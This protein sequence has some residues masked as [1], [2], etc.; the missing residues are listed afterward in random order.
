MSHE[1]DTPTV[2]A[3]T[4]TNDTAPTETSDG[5]AATDAS[6][7]GS[8]TDSAAPAPGR[9]PTKDPA[10]LDIDENVRKNF[11][12]DDHPDVTESIREHGVKSPIK[13]IRMP[14]GRLV[15]RDGQVRTLTA[16]AFGQTEVP[17]WITDFDPAVDAA[18]AEI[19]RILEQITVNDR[20][21]PLTDG[22]RAA[23]IA[24]ALDLGASVTRVG[25][26]LQTKRDDVKRAGKIGASA[27]AR[28]LVD[29]GQYDLEQAAVI[30]EYDTLGDTDAVERL[31]RAN[32]SWF[33]YEAN[34][35]AEDRAEVRA[36]LAAALPYAEAGVG[37]LTDYPHDEQFTDDGPLVL[38]ADLVDADG[39][40]VDIDHINANP[41][42]WSV[43]L[44]ISEDLVWVEVDT[45]ALVDPDTVDWDT[46]DHPDAEPAEGLRHAREV[47]Q[48]E[49]L[50]A[51]YFLPRDLLEA[52]GLR[53]RKQDPDTGADGTDPSDA[54]Q[55]DRDGQ[56][57]H[58]DGDE[59]AAA[60]RTAAAQDAARAEA[61]AREQ[62]RM[63][64]RRVRELNKQG[65]AAKTTRTEFVTRLL[66]RKTSPAQAPVFLAQAL[67]SDSGL[68]SECHAFGTAVELL[69]IKGFRGRDELLAALE[70]AKPARAQVIVLA[71]VLGAYESRCE[72][73][74][75]RYADR[76]V[77]RYLAF[78]RELGHPLVPVELAALGEVKSDDIDIDTPSAATE[79]DEPQQAEAA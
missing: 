71:L 61:E 27:T 3:D 45:G 8:D 69:G 33:S 5:A 75:W 46:R 38:A 41:G 15:V 31:M 12:L 30:G 40:A 68:L 10:L 34:R 72:K 25:K 16:L 44:E 63:V 7:V 74:L 22:D 21:I 14:D 36:Y 6:D 62:E 32:R 48:R 19:D 58:G 20:R 50:L 51:E 54:D 55:G 24:L 53:E 79:P 42:F 29:E 52:A 78:L 49:H 66:T 67:V 60:R 73:T 4:D 13:V 17:V 39:A 18:E 35:I 59:L 2:E 9:G 1:T 23:G 77:R 43:W 28:G 37:I 11:R 47:Q 64:R 65:L 56:G 26:A 57:G 70:T 76:G